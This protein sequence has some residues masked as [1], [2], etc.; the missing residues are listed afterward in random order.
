M[1]VFMNKRVFSSI[2]PLLILVVIGLG[3]DIFEDEERDWKNEVT[4]K[5]FNDS[6]CLVDVKINGTEMGS[7]NPGEE[8][9]EE[10]LGQGVHFLEAYPWNDA[11]FSCASN[12]SPELNTGDSY[13]WTI[14]NET[15]CGV[16]EP[17][18][19]PAPETPTPTATPTPES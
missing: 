5:I 18:P 7:L 4:I 1:H 17:T 16:C 19:T 12:T 13:Q 10:D 11:Q 14:T 15:A 8:I 9:E 2:L 3:C 6:N